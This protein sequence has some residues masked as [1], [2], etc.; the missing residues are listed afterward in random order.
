[1][2][3]Q[4]EGG[5][6]QDKKRG[7]RREVPGEAKP[8]STVTLDFS[9]QNCQQKIHFCCSSQQFPNLLG[10]RDGRQLF[11]RLGLG[12]GLGMIRAHYICCGLYFYYYYIAFTSDHQALNPGSW[13]P[14]AQATMVWYL[15][16]LP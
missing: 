2:G 7:L 9:L 10:T 3:T 5:C 14:L 1:M 13:G 8:A 6:L 12:D 11:H 16:W 15:I 4:L